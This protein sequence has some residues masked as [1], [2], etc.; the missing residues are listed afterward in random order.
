MHRVEARNS[1]SNR[2]FSSQQTHNLNIN[3]VIS[4][5]LRRYAIYWLRFQYSLLFELVCVFDRVFVTDSL[6]P[7]AFSGFSASGENRSCV[8]T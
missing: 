6:L 7:R 4:N 3:T 8:L 1:L 5:I 2:S